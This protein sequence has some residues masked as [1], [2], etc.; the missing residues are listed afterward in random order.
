MKRNLNTHT[1]FFAGRAKRLVT[2][3]VGCL[4]LTAT[5]VI[6]SSQAKELSIKR[7]VIST[8]PISAENP[9]ELGEDITAELGEDITAELGG[10]IEQEKEGTIAERPGKPDGHNSNGDDVLV[11]PPR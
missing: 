7:A 9:T 10:D 11:R 8:E 6:A 3:L 2:S 5:F 1:L 4:I